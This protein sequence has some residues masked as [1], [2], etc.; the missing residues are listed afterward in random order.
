MLSLSCFQKS[1]FWFH[2]PSRYCTI[3]CIIFT[4]ETKPS[5]KAYILSLFSITFF[6]FFPEYTSIKFLPPISTQTILTCIINYLKATCNGRHLTWT[7]HS[8]FQSRLFLPRGEIHSRKPS[9]THFIF[10]YYYKL[11]YFNFCL[12]LVCRNKTNFSLLNLYLAT[13]LSSLSSLSGF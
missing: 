1:F 9:L 8:I 13:L 4:E 5:Q 10:L 6:T 11:Y 12:M 7:T 3:S 2:S